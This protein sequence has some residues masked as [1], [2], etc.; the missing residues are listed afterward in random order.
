MEDTHI[1]AAPDSRYVGTQTVAIRTLDSFWDE[2]RPDRQP[3]FLKIDTQGY[4]LQVLQGSE[5]F[6]GHICGLQL[7]MNLAN[8]YAA[9]VGFDELWQFVTAL[10]F[11][12]WGF[13]PG[14][15]DEA[16]GRMLSVDGVFFRG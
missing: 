15:T 1:A 7:E 8:L 6:L 2:L 11:D 5:R 4:E 3:T 13:T 10:G 12:C 14:F 16:S 9:Q